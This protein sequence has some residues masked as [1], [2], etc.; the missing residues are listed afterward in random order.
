M[1]LGK[2]E[3]IKRFLSKSDNVDDLKNLFLWFNSEKG[4]TEINDSLEKKW[5]SFE[6][7]DTSLHVDS[8]KILLNIKNEIRHKKTVQLKNNFTRLLPYAAIIFVII[9]FVVILSSHNKLKKQSN[10]NLYASVMTE[11]GQRSKVVLPDSSIVWLNSGTT[12]SYNYS[13]EDTRSII[14]NGEGFFQVTRNVNKPFV[15][16][17]GD[18]KVKV[19]G[20]KFDVSAYPDNDKISV[21]LESGSVLLNHNQCTLNYKLKP[22]EQADYDKKAKEIN[23]HSADVEKDTSWKDGKLIFR[24]DPMK[25]VIKQLERWYNIQVE[26]KDPEVYNSIFTGTVINEGYQQIFKLIEYSCPVHCEIVNNLNPEEIPKII[27]T[28]R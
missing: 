2:M 6:Y 1:N 18:I 16:Q 21:V 28:K 5:R 12:L 25:L 24:N 4:H 15:V 14:L 8:A 7:D 23:I 9:G 20:T 11:N 26:V 17:C 13:A 22:G 19:L 3:T 27:I 10:S